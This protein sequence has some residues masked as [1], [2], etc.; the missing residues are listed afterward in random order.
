[1]SNQATNAEAHAKAI[2]RDLKAKLAAA[3]AKLVDIGKRRDAVALG[4]EMGD[5]DAQNARTV[6][7]READAVERRIADLTPAI[8]A[9]EARV[10]LAREQDVALAERA[11]KAAPIY[12]RL[13]K[14]GAAIDAGFRQAIENCAAMRD[15]LLELERLGAGAPNSRLVEVNVRQAADAALAGLHGEVRIVAPGQRRSFAEL[16]TGWARMAENWAAAI[17]DAPK[18]K[19][20]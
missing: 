16:C 10:P 19:A 17:L 13:A 9:A 5:I 8:A 7:G 14:R 3:R 6:L 2:V 11:R 1:L 15:D 12:A 18:D 20:A 4:A